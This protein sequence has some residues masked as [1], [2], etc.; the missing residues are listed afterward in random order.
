[1]T[2]QVGQA[3]CLR[4]ARD[5]E[6]QR[7]RRDDEQEVSMNTTGKLAA[8]YLRVSTSAQA[9]TG[10]IG[11]PINLNGKSFIVVGVMPRTFQFPTRKDQ[12]W[13]PLA[14]DAKEAGQR[15]NHYLEVI[16]RM[17]PKV[18][19]QQAQAVLA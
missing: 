16:A 19:L 3:K 12:L 9:D 8:I 15:G 2:M 13:V 18:S 17:K 5:V 7:V 4:R 6:Q 1:M 14:I 11:K 10:I